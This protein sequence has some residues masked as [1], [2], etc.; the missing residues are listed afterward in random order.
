MK[1]LEGLAE[2]IKKNLLEQ[3]RVLWTHAST[4]IEGNTLT[5]GET[6]FV[7]SEGLT[8]SGKPL[9]DHRDIEGHA[10]AVDL[11]Y[12]LVK[13]QEILEAD[14][15]DLHK[16]V[17]YEQV[18]DVYKPVGDWKK[19]NNSTSVTVHNQLKTIEFSDHW[20]VPKLMERWLELLNAEIQSHK[21]RKEV[22][23]SYARLHISLTGIHPFWDGNGRIARLIAN[24]PC[25]KAGFPPIIIEN[26]KRYDYITALAG[27]TLTHGVPSRDTALV[28][29]DACFDKFT[30]FCEQCWQGSLTLVEES[31][32]LQRKR[33]Q[34]L[35]RARTKDFSP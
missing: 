32:D 29:E 31:H 22:L 10:H 11:V 15:F 3:L 27:Y 9:K 17:I 14:L 35:S 16:L 4:A 2:D 20:E 19:E 34:R 25:L 5:L 28:H 30:S 1:F 33:D 23:K 8:I 26:E 7:L 21:A 18:L 12:G 13:K 24:L 6:A